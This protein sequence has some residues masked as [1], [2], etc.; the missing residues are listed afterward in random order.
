M[1]T[2]NEIFARHQL[3]TRRQQPEESLD[4]FLQELRK[5][6]KN[7]NYKAV[8]SEQYREEQVG[9]AFITGISS[10]HIRQ[11]LL[12]NAVLDMQS[13][14][15]QAR[16]LDIAQKNSAVY[17]PTHPVV[18]TVETIPPTSVPS[19]I[20]S[21]SNVPPDLVTVAALPTSTLSVNR[22]C[23]FCGNLSHNRKVCPGRSKPLVTQSTTAAIF[24]PTLC[25]VHDGCPR[26]LT[27]AAVSVEISDRVLTALIDTCSSDNFISRA[28]VDD[29]QLKFGSLIKTVSMALSTVPF[30]FVGSCGI[31]IVLSG[32][33]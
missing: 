32:N 3:L 27:H 17:Q 20:S 15:D 1:K 8:T 22:K 24:K 25:A 31:N 16:A 5:L 23:M 2:P 30:K 33:L 9:D 29:L 11:R 28:V 13:A 12:E 4:N 10:K 7:C 6:S 18:A 26:S 14:F 21:D 19:S